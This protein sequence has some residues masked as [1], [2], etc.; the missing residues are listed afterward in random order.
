MSQKKLTSVIF[1]FVGMVC[2]EKNKMALVPLMRLDGRRDLPP[3]CDKRE[4]LFAFKISQVALS[5]QDRRVWRENLAP[6]D[7]LFT[8]SAVATSGRG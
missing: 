1:L 6:A 3:P 4:E 8:A 5:G 7:V 2:L